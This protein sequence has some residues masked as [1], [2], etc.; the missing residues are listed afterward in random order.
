VKNDEKSQGSLSLNTPRRES[1]FNNKIQYS[2]AEEST[3][4]EMKFF[5]HKQIEKRI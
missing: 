2:N 1:S 5:M 4:Q 3:N